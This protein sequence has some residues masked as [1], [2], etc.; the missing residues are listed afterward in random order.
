[1]SGPYDQEV[2]VAQNAEQ[3]TPLQRLYPEPMGPQPA[4]PYLRPVTLVISPLPE[5]GLRARLRQRIQA[6][7]APEPPSRRVRPGQP[8]SSDHWRRRPPCL[9][10]SLTARIISEAQ[11][12]FTRPAYRT[13][14]GT[15][16]R[17][18]WIHRG[19]VLSLRDF[20]HQRRRL[21]AQDPFFA[22]ATL[23]SF[24]AAFK[25]TA[26]TTKR[27]KCH[28]ADDQVT[29]ILN[30]PL[31]GTIVAKIPV[32]EGGSV[33][34]RLLDARK[35]ALRDRRSPLAHV[36]ATS[37]LPPDELESQPERSEEEMDTVMLD[38]PE[39][40]SGARE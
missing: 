34:R 37:D 31:P 10:L 13:A 30:M 2:S 26:A 3:V 12:D 39:T 17:P 40:D 15:R 9:R 14:K 29:K 36:L 11:Y 27:R 33:K 8:I 22:T 16:A 25:S 23:A 18:F 28:P 1:M 7:F 32:L 4:T 6:V 20:R 19:T 24:R 35:Q 38:A 5:D 21:R